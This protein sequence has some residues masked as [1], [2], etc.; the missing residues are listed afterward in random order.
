MNAA[1]RYRTY[2]RGA[3]GDP[4]SSTNST[5]VFPRF[6][7]GPRFGVR[8]SFIPL[9]VPF[10]SLSLFLCL[11]FPLSALFIFAP[12][13]LLSM[14][15]SL[16]VVLFES[17]SLWLHSFSFVSLLLSTSPLSSFDLFLFSSGDPLFPDDAFYLGFFA[18][19]DYLSL[20]LMTFCTSLSVFFSSVISS[21][22]RACSFLVSFCPSV[23]LLA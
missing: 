3:A 14:V 9:V 21:F 17:P 7:F 5:S 22:S 15:S 23:F 1:R 19:L 18:P 2:R 16:L 20:S 4:S 11:P 6:S 10:A 13:Q 12:P 8:E